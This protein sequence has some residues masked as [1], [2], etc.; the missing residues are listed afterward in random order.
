M[1]I[2]TYRKP[3]LYGDVAIRLRDLIRDICKTMEVEIITGHISKDHV[4]ILVSVPPYVSVS[5]LVRRIIGKS[6]RELLSEYRRLSQPF[7]GRHLWARGY[8][9]ATTGTITDE[10]IA[11]YIEMQADMERARDDDISISE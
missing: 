3:V 4:H 10:V 2:T 11:R 7:W 1:W 9:A 6:S 5:D 8:V